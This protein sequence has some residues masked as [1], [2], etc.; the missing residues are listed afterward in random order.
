MRVLAVLT[1]CV[2][3][4]AG[5][6]RRESEPKETRPLTFEELSDTTGLSQGP[7]VVRTFEPYRM[8]N[9]ALRARGRLRFPDGTRVQLS[10]YPVGEATLLA[11]TQF[12]VV[13]E[14]FDTPPILGSSGP[15][16]DGAYR[17][18]LLT[19]FEQAWQ[20][21]EVMEQTGNGRRLRGPGFTR[22]RNGEAA[23]V[24]TEEHR[25]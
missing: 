17:F 6:G 16:P 15:L 25:L 14:R 2:L 11:R 9:M 3:T 22:G 4:I 21:P 20:P 1:A 10:I 18:E 5:C 13:D 7:E 8:D 24:H 12:E 19:Y 23:F